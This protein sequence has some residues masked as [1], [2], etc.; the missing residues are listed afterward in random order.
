VRAPQIEK[1]AH[2]ELGSVGLLVQHSAVAVRADAVDA[3]KRL[4]NDLG[5]NALGE[6]GVV[7]CDLLQEAARPDRFVAR[8]VFRSRA[9]LEAHAAT[10]HYRRWREAAGPLL[11]GEEA[12]RLLDTLYPRSS[13]FPFRSRW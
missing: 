1:G 10:A 9:A 8:K 5:Y 6:H 12:T 11:L 4:W 7:R 13:P 3:F 2:D